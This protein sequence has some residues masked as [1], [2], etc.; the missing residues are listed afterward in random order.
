MALRD[1]EQEPAAQAR[2]VSAAARLQA[3]P[4]QEQPAPRS[5]RQAPQQGEPLWVSVP[6]VSQPQEQELL[7]QA[8]QA[9]R[10]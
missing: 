4:A 2:A 8:P 3:E 10:A 5:E 6:R 1:E 7:R 9:H